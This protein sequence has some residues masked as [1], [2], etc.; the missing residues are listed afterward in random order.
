MV[1]GAD[2]LRLPCVRGRPRA[3]RPLVGS[4]AAPGAVGGPV[5]ALA[6]CCCGHVRSL[7]RSD[8]GRGP[9][10]CYGLEGRADQHECPCL[11]FCGERDA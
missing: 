3:T 2:A 10:R 9:Q 11:D 8:D 5:T 7:H 4:P 6:R 1:P